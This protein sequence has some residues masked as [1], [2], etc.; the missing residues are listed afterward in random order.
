MDYTPFDK[1]HTIWSSQGESRFSY[2]ASEKLVKRTDKKAGGDMVTYYVGGHEAIYQPDGSSEIKRY[3]RDIAIHTIKSTGSQSL[4]YVFND[5]LG[6]GSVI[7]DANGNVV[8]TASF[9][10]FGKRR[11]AKLW[12]GYVDPF[13]H[14]PNLQALLNITQK[15]YT[16]HIQVDHASI[17]H[18]GGRIYDPDLGRFIQ[19]DPI[20]Q[21]PRDA[22]S[23]NRYSYVY[24]NPLSYTDPT[25]YAADCKSKECPA[26][27][28]QQ[29]QDT[30]KAEKT[31]GSSKA[32]DVN[33][34]NQSAD[35]QN[36]AKVASGSST[37]P[38]F[39]SGLATNIVEG[40]GMMLNN[41]FVDVANAQMDVQRAE[42]EG[43]P[44]SVDAAKVALLSTTLPA[45][46]MALTPSPTTGGKPKADV[47]N[48][49]KGEDNLVYRGGS[50]TPT[51]LTPRAKDTTGLSGN[52]NPMPGKNQVIDTSKL[53][54]LC[55]VCDN[56]KTGHVSIKPKDMSQ[57]Q[58]WI[59]SRGSGTAH[60]LTQELMDAV[61]DQVKK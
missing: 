43:N 11:D 23:L 49:T 5:H 46:V 35:L 41:P 2:D 44:D 33:K 52:V 29:E 34:G 3:I 14:L 48:V 13:S 54:K 19:A 59:D 26:T 36:S 6:S 9:D 21:D 17:I 55:A 27:V 50:G 32:Q 60:P 16:G 8:E 51:N 47:K 15:G 38:S 45:V 20:V 7:T 31:R 22:Q 1:P 39:L 58:G 4:H 18:M 24:N 12:G 37:Q 56:A 30:A 28:Y 10:A 40:M 61:V 25:G 42:L 53:D 57:M